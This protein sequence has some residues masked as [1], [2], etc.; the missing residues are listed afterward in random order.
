MAVLVLAQAA[1]CLSLSTGNGGT[2][3]AGGQ[4]GGTGGLD[5]VPGGGGAGGDDGSGVVTASSSSGGT[6]SSGLGQAC[7]EASECMSGFCVDGVCCDVACDGICVSCARPSSLGTCTSL[8]AQ[9]EDQGG[10]CAI[11]SA[12]DGAGV[13]K[14]KNGQPCAQNDE[15]LSNTCHGGMMTCVP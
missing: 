4:G 13:C 11:T 7:I 1:G 8:P 12:C 15:C 10:G 3:G 5:V 2:G 9:E 14:L 6:S